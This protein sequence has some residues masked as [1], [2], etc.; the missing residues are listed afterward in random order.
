MCCLGFRC[1]VL[2]VCVDSLSVLLCCVASSHVSRA[3]VLAFLVLCWRKCVGGGFFASYDVWSRLLYCCA[4]GRVGSGVLCWVA[5]V[6]FRCVVLKKMCCF[7]VSCVSLF[8]FFFLSCL[9][10]WRRRGESSVFCRFHVRA[11]VLRGKGKHSWS[12]GG[13]ENGTWE[14]ETRW[15]K[16]EKKMCNGEEGRKERSY[17]S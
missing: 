3:V 14:C 10:C 12:A 16:R 13:Q 8:S 5:A 17:F 2:K 1:V 11:A 6:R 4:E 7:P 9:L 15:W